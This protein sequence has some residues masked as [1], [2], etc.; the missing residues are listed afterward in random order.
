MVAY[1]RVRPEPTASAAR[2]AAGP[3]GNPGTITGELQTVNYL[4]ANGKS[5]SFQASIRI[6]LR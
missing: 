5:R 6:K 3:D 1:G 4:S 2:Q